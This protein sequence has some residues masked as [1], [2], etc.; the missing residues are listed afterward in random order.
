[1]IQTDFFALV[2]C[3]GMIVSYSLIPSKLIGLK[4]EKDNL[5]CNRSA[6]DTKELSTFCT[7]LQ[8]YKIRQIVP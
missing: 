4:G 5:F 6:N 8:Y 7:I 2:S 1:M 3:I